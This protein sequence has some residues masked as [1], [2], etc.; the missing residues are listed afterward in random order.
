M[1]RQLFELDPDVEPHVVPMTNLANA[2]VR[3]DFLARVLDPQAPRQFLTFQQ[4]FGG[5]IGLP[6][7][8][9]NP[10]LS[11]DLTVV[12]VTP[13]PNAEEP[14]V[15]LGRYGVIE[16]QTTDTH[17]TYRHAVDALRGALDLH[18]ADFAGEVAKHPDWPGR[19]M[20]GPNISNVFKR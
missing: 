13:A 6:G 15:R 8:H 4:L 11:F 2:K 16:I 1:V 7:S 5:E 10:E 18:Q 3:N 14:S 9:A 12:E 17:G 20:E 19:R